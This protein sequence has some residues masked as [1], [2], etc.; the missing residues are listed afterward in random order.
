MELEDFFERKV[1]SVSGSK[2]LKEDDPEGETSSNR[3]KG[4]SGIPLPATRE[5]QD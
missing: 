5:T 4:S 2:E 3:P 1:T